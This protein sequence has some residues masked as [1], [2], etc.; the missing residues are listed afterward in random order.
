MGMISNLIRVKLLEIR[1][2]T[3]PVVILIDSTN[4]FSSRF[5]KSLKDILW[6]EMYST[7][8]NVAHTTLYSLDYDVRDYLDDAD[9]PGPIVLEMNPEDFFQQTAMEVL[10]ERLKSVGATNVV[11]FRL[12]REDK[13]MDN[14]WHLSQ[15][16]KQRAK[17]PGLKII[18]MTLS[19][20]R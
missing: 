4:E 7:F 18:S 2:L 17:N 6:S 16:D 20:P 13:Q 11:V 12:I 5:K 1:E 9:H 3:K 10:F 19:K 14:D 15:L 8:Q